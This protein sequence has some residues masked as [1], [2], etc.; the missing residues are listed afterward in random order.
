MP[1]RD[2]PIPPDQD[3][4]HPVEDPPSNPDVQTPNAPV[5]EPGPTPPKRF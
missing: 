1:N 3:H 5:R 2:I 4:I